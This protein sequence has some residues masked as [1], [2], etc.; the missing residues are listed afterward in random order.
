MSG[1]YQLN[2]ATG[3]VTLPSSGNT[4][5]G[6]STNSELYSVD[7]SGTVTV[8][9]TG[10]G[11]GS[12][13]TGSFATTGSNTFSGS[14]NI[15]GDVTS[16]GVFHAQ[17]LRIMSGSSAVY[18]I[19]SEDAAVINISSS[20]VNY[21]P[22]A[23]ITP[24]PLVLQTIHDSVPSAN[25]KASALLLA[26]H[27]YNDDKTA[28]TQL[29]TINM[30]TNNHDSAFTIMLRN[31]VG[32]KNEVLRLLSDG[33]TIMS[34]SLVVDS[35][36]PGLSDKGVQV[37]GSLNTT[38]TSGLLSQ[39]IVD[40][41][42]EDLSSIFP[43][44]NIASGSVNGFSLNSGSNSPAI[45]VGTVNYTNINGITGSILNGAAIS[46]SSG[47]TACSVGLQKIPGGI[48]SQLYY[49]PDYAGGNE[50]YLVQVGDVGGENRLVIQKADTLGEG[51]QLK[52]SDIT[53]GFVLDHSFSNSSASLFKVKDNGSV[54]TIFNITG[55]GTQAY[56][57]LTGLSSDFTA[58][59]T[60]G[61]VYARIS[62]SLTCSIQPNSVVPIPTGVEFEFFQYS[63][64]QLHFDTGSGVV[65][66]SK[67]GNVKLT[68]QFS[69]A[70]LKKVDTDEW[71]LIGDLS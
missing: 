61:G 19:G 57:P 32:N 41:I 6:T 49:N 66:N 54:N 58:S 67:N 10:S 64:H 20:N 33:S 25:T 50:S 11:G 28:L 63:N 26:S 29:A 15:I 7:S 24:N 56:R 48:Q 18:N 5:I 4:F 1:I 22:N 38:H 34:G 55:T 68:G 13:D 8:Y 44:Y 62:G 70:I 52:L 60:G 30:A 43:A 17:Q 2:Q 31:G 16:S 45:F 39:G 37:T 36:L 59:I 23:T 42:D 9:G 46:L 35:T 3:S 40:I 53:E 21:S 47:S 71:D 14:Q 27:N 12:I 51:V 65:M 69:A